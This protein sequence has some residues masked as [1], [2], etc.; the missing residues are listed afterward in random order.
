MGGSHPDFMVGLEY[1]SSFEIPLHHQVQKD[2]VSN[3]MY[4][5]VNHDHFLT[6][7]RKNNVTDHR[8]N[9]RVDTLHLNLISYNVFANFTHL[10]FQNPC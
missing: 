9:L 4:I 7:V 2:Q 8:K 6:T 3:I 10:F 5:F 1:H